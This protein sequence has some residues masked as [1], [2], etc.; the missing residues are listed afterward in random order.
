MTPAV[1]PEP[2]EATTGR[3][4]SIDLGGGKICLSWDAGFK[5]PSALMRLRKRQVAGARDMTRA[6][7]WRG[8]GIVPSNRPCGSGI[9]DLRHGG[10]R[11]KRL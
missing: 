2:Q 7:A 1:T 3:S 11:S 4:V 5:V 8:S 10:C 9:D 6:Q